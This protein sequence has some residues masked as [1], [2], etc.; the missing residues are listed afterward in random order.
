MLIE[1]ELQQFLEGSM[2]A[3]EN[4]LRDQK[5][6]TYYYGF[7]ESAWPT[8]EEAGAAFGVNHRERTRQIIQSKFKNLATPA[9][10]PSASR[11]AAQIEEFDFVPASDIRARLIAQGLA[12]EGTSLRGL[13]RLFQDLGF[14][15]D[16]GVYDMALRPVT[17]AASH[18]E[19]A[20]FLIRSSRLSILADARKKVV[21]LPGLLGLAKESYIPDEL[22]GF[23]S[24]T[25]L[26]IKALL[27][28]D[29]DVCFVEVSGER[30]FALE[31]RDNTLINRCEKLFGIVAAC[32]SSILAQV[33]DN[34]FS[35][36][37]SELE[38][39]SQDV[40]KAFLKA[41]RHFEVQGTTVRFRGHP[42]ELTPIES[43]VVAYLRQ[44]GVVDYPQIRDHLLAKGYGKPHID[45]AVTSSPL[46]YVDK[47]LGRTRHTYQLVP[48]VPT[49]QSPTSALYQSIHKRLQRLLQ[50]GTDINVE[51]SRRREQAILQDWLFS[52]KAVE[53]CA[54]CGNT[55]SCSAL[56]AAH[57]KPRSTCTEDERLDPYIVMPMCV[58]GCDYL[59]EHGHLIVIGDTV[60]LGVSMSPTQESVYAGSLVGRKIPE[61]WLLGD[62][63]YFSRPNHNPASEPA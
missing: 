8:L 22:Q 34:A 60:A 33:L 3:G 11:A 24:Q 41:S 25:L 63:S 31:E 12:D 46:V 40:I 50:D 47:S 20:C 43:D 39:P 56:V 21:T 48:S 17:R 10:L 62:P 1:E 32:D 2:R 6:I 9:A 58:F 26:Q 14:C 13:L 29:P 15:Q 52:G 35:R 54:I 36:R 18:H 51:S 7:D 44:H 23:D 45:K 42:T 55:F 61:Q 57:K 27:E 49:P 37:S 30:W 19:D 59:Y 16:Y 38:Y 5:I 28:A 53:Q 4:K